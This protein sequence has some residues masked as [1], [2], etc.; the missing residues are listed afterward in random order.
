MRDA[1][2]WISYQIRTLMGTAVAGLQSLWLRSTG[3]FA[4]NVAVVAGGTGIAQLISVAFSPIITR[5]YGPEAYGALSL[6]TSIVAVGA[7]IATMGYSF[8][9]VLPKCDAVAYQLLKLAV[10]LACVISFS[11]GLVLTWFQAPIVSAFNLDTVAPYIWLI[12]IGMFVAALVQAM[13]QWLVRIGGFKPLAAAAVSKAGIAGGTRISA[14]LVAPSAAA[15]IVLGVIAQ[16]VQVTILFLSGQ[17]RIKGA[18]QASAS[19]K[20]NKRVAL[21]AVARR[22]RDF[23]QYRA[24][25]MLLNTLS[26]AA[27]MVLLASLFGTGVVGLYAIAQTVLYLPVDLIAQS[28][29][30]VFL[31]RLA[32]QA[33]DRKP[34]RPLILRATVGLVLLGLLPF[35]IIIL[36]GPWLF[37]FVFGADWYEAGNYARWLGVWVFF[38]FINV[39]AVQ[40]L[41][42]SNS[43]GILL[44]W[45]IMTTVVKVILLL[46]VGTLAK[47]AELTVAV[48]AVF[49][50]LAYIILIL[51]GIIRA[52]DDARIRH[53]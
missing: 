6:F 4:R 14:G 41:A 53:A 33:H 22:F 26:R 42:V 37:G 8:A 18:Q 29:G 47:D 49:G 9:I 51:I 5:L 7:S 48:Y 2:V 45:E 31:Q 10:L 32:K 12:P 3:S 1:P 40:S 24:P 44:I 36:G 43:Q 25:Q 19:V 21:K 38:H 16:V 39:P 50:A 11:A 46:L 28:V 13:E 17:Q 52:G 27:P 20:Q 35:G 34:L 23:P 15:L 30:K